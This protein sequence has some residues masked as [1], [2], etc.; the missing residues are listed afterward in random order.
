MFPNIKS[1]WSRQFKRLTIKRPTASKYY[2][3]EYHFGAIGLLIY[4]YKIID[5]T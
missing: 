5:W 3:Q 1:L 4:K 2:R